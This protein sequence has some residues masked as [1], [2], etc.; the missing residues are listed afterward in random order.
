MG[1]LVGWSPSGELVIARRGTGA[2]AAETLLV[3]LNGGAPRSIAIP[4][5]APSRPGETPPDPIAR[6]SPDGRSM[7]LSRVSRGWETFVIE[8]PLAAGRPTTTGRR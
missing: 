7:V 5:F 3:P 8:N 4:R 6:L 1:N 2:A